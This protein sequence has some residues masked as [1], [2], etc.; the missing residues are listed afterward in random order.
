MKFTPFQYQLPML[1]WAKEKDSFCYFASPGLGKTVVTLKVLSDRIASGASRGALVVAPLRVAA[2]TW[3]AQ[4]ALWDHSSWMRVAHLRH[5]SGIKAWNEGT[6]EIYLVNPEHLQKLCPVLF[7]GRD[8]IPVDTFIWDELSLAK[9]R[10][11]KRANSLRPYLPMFKHRIGLTGSP[12]PNDYL[13]LFAQ[14]RMLDDGARLSRS[15]FH[16]RQTYFEQADY[17][18]Y[19]WEL[20][21]GAKDVIDRKLSDLCLV[22][23]GDDHLDVPTCTTVD[24][25]VALPDNARR[26]YK[27]LE[28]ELLTQ[29]NKSDVV[30]LTAATLTN[31]LL[32]VT[33]GALYD[34]EHRAHA[35]HDAKLDA[36]KAL[37]KKHAGS[38]LLVLCA[39]KSE[40]ARVLAA[41]PGAEEFDEKRLDDWRAGRIPMWVTDARRLSHGIDG[42]QHGGRIAVWM[43]LTWSNET[44]LQTNA[45]LV[46]TGQAHETTIYRILVPDSID[47]AVAEALRTKSDTQSGL[48]N[49]LKAL[50]QLRNK[51]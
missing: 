51:P 38:P 31:K 49:A 8:R 5:P 45:R 40:V 16:Y 27:E 22:M 50:Q 37:R 17:M 7:K 28:K 48:F 15:F 42:L 10:S 9:S 46:R 19:K 21:E 44:Y 36:L 18:G 34:D 6:A 25:P 43:T 14:I 29:V 2:I 26:H 4:V 23:L 11:S 20:R 33:S 47:D 35:V 30:A 12:V 24:V 3:P 41:I 1:E 13:D 39:F 32:Q